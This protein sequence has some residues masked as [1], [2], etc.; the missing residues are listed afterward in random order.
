MGGGGVSHDQMGN[1]NA[2]GQLNANQYMT[3]VQQEQ[4]AAAPAAPA[5]APYDARQA[6]LT[7]L[8]NPGPVTTLGAT[9]RR[10]SR[11]PVS[12]TCW[13]ASLLR[14]R[15]ARARATITT[16]RFFQHLISLTRRQG[17]GSD[18]MTTHQFEFTGIDRC[19]MARRAARWKQGGA[20]GPS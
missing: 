14:I 20:R 6:A 19:N 9:S 15:A 2:I 3:G 13:R 4:P 7:A 11:F 16:S 18:D 12:R 8:A 10:R 5:A 17:A 1:Y